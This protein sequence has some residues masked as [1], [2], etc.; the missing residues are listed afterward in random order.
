MVPRRL[1]RLKKPCP[2]RALRSPAVVPEILDVASREL[3]AHAAFYEEKR[4]GYGARF[5]DEVEELFLLIDQSPFLGAPWLLDE[6]P[7]GVRHVV[8]RTFPVSIVYVTEP[9]TIVV[10][11][12]GNQDPLHWIDRLDQ[13]R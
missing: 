4:V 5:A 1:Y 12:V 3:S 10:G 13:I 6:V 8:L 7:A 9:R 2:R 11:F